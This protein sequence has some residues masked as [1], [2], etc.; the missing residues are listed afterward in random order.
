MKPFAITVMLS[1]SLFLTTP[2]SSQ[3]T[4]PAPMNVDAIFARPLSRLGDLPVAIGG[5]AEVNSQYVGTDGVTEG[6]SFQMPRATFFLSSSPAERMSFFLELEFEEGGREIALETALLDIELAPLF[7]LRG[8]VLLNPI[9]AFNQN[10]D[11]PKWEFVDRPVSATRMLPAT[12]S[13]VGFGGHGRLF[14]GPRTWAWEFYLT[15]GFDESII[16]NAENRTFLPAAKENA[17]R[18]EESSNGMPLLTGKLALRQRGVGEIG[19]SW[20]GGVYNRFEA[21]GLTIDEKRRLDVLAV[22]A[23]T[24]IGPT[25]TTITAEGAWVWVDVPPTYSQQFGDRQRGGFVDIVQPFLRSP[26]FGFERSV[27][28]AA[29][30]LEYVDWNMGKFAET[31]TDIGDEFTAVV[32][33]LSWRPSAQTVLRLNY[34]REWHVDLL[35]NPASKTAAIQFGLATYF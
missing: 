6:L 14:D 19:V 4:L 25:G 11:G 13:T 33:A 17:E 24:T 21:D 31:G 10:H 1:G 27:L 26:L 23:S 29:L 2:A 16:S 18:F 28:S 30:R 35:G 20:M 34:R 32:P 7:V 9:G 3:D 12:W 5:Y 15:N 22:D 8:G